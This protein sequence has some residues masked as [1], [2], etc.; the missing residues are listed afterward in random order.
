MHV[1]FHI[2]VWQDVFFGRMTLDM[3]KEELL[4]CYLADQGYTVEAYHM[5]PQKISKEKAREAIKGAVIDT[6]ARVLINY[7]RGGI[8]QGPMGH[9]H[10]SP[11][12][13]YNQEMDAFLVMD[14][15]KYKL[16]QF[17]FWPPNSLPASVPWTSVS[18]YVILILR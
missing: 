7:D 9:G 11:I 12:C 14:V 2:D 10:F 6:E 17:G 13:A 5:D 16:L 3:A 1:T 8:G 18:I 4:D 15:A